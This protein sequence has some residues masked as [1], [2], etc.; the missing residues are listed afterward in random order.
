MEHVTGKVKKYSREYTRTLKDGKKKKYQT[1]QVQITIPKQ[2]NIFEDDEEVLIFHNSDNDFVE[3]QEDITIALE[4]HNFLLKEE[5]KKL[6]E[7]LKVKNSIISQLNEE[8]EYLNQEIENK[9][10]DNKLLKTDYHSDSDFLELQKSYVSLLK[11]NEILQSQLESAKIG[12]LYQQG[13]ANK[14]RNFIL[15]NAD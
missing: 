1:E 12:E 11:K 14:F 8:I 6:N 3:S 4:L 5:T 10:N 15:Y 13:L 9:T 7:D 2:Q